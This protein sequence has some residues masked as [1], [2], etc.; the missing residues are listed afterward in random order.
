MGAMVI[1]VAMKPVMIAIHPAPAPRPRPRPPDQRWRPTR[2]LSAPHRLGFVAAA[3]MMAATALWWAAMLAARALGAAV[4]WAVAPPLAHGAAMALAFMPLFIIGFLF[5]A[6]P[7]WLG[8]PDVSA[9]SLVKPVLAYAAGW[10]I[11][12]VGFHVSALA[13]AAGVALAASAWA[14]VVWRFMRMLRASPAPDRLHATGVAA[15][16]GVGLFAMG[17]LAFALAR[18][19]VDLARAATQLALWGFL[20]PVF[21]TVSHRMIPFFTAS[22]LPSLEAWRPNSLL[23]VMLVALGACA[24]GQVAEALWWPL[25]AA[26]HAALLAVHAPAAGLMLWLALRWGL[27]QSLR[28]RLLAMLHGGFVWLGI[29]FALGALSHA[30]VLWRGETASLGLAPLH[31]LTLGYLGA[32]LFAMVTRVVAG[33]SGRPLAADDAALALYLG[34]QTAAVL[35]VVAALWPRAATA[36][37]LLAAVC[38]GFAC[39]GW[40]VRYGGWLGRPRVDGRP[41]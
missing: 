39:L 6:G 34:V 11:A 33:H 35:R 36:A 31:A 3:F 16:G 29:A 12:L 30:L 4:P 41:G 22:A 7:R 10:C 24:L 13:A 26:A 9:R 1:A 23:A 25:P 40:A 18:Q 38:W 5:T 32:T 20:A 2:L 21:A 27:V 15:A 14:T 28:V 19:Q 17:V 8:L 37:T